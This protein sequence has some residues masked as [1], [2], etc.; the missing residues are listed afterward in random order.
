M[1]L[2]LRGT[3]RLAAMVVFSL[4]LAACET[5]PSQNNFA[6]ITFG[7]LPEIKLNVG[8]IVYESRYKAP[9]ALPNVDHVFPVPPARAAERWA[10]D[11]L[12]AVGSDNKAVFILKDASVTEEHLATKGGIKGA[13]TTEQT[14]RYKARMDVEIQI[15]DNFGN[16]LS[17]ITA[18]VERTTTTPEDLSL[19]ERE[20]V[21]FRLTEDVMRDLDMQLDPAIKRVFF[22]YLTF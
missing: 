6:E 15:V 7:H 21:W 9:E 8:E 20:K 3:A 1:R 19:R 12:R 16:A 14:E 10:H 22:P 4:F 11:R 13:F 2:V 18:N 5:P 17:N